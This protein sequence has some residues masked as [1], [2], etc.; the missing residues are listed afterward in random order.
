M[1]LRGI[2]SITPLLVIGA[3]ST[4]ADAQC[5][6]GSYSYG[7]GQ[8]ASCPAG[9][10]FVSA[11]SGCAPSASLTS[12]PPDTAFYLSG[13]GS[14]EVLAFPAV[15]APTSVSAAAG[16]F[17]AQS[18]G[19]LELSGGSHLSAPGTSAPEALPGGGNVPWSASAWVK[20]AAPETH[21]TGTA[22]KIASVLEWG[23]P[24]DVLGAASTQAISLDVKV[25]ET[26]TKV[27]DV[28]VSTL[29]I[30]PSSISMSAIAVMADGSVIVADTTGG[31]LLV[32]YLSP[33]SSDLATLAGGAT[34]ADGS[35]ARISMAWDPGLHVVTC[36]ENW[37]CGP[38]TYYYSYDAP[39][40]GVGS[41]ASFGDLMFSNQQIVVGMTQASSLD[42]VIVTES[43]CIRTISYPTGTVTTLAG[44]C[45]LQCCGFTNSMWSPR[46]GSALINFGAAD[47]TGTSAKFLRPRFPSFVESIS[48]IFVLDG[49]MIRSISYPGAV[50][51]S[52]KMMETREGSFAAC[53][54][55]SGFLGLAAAY[56]IAGLPMGN[57]IVLASGD[58]PQD[59][60]NYD[61]LTNSYT[62]RSWLSVLSFSDGLHTPL[63]GSCGSLSVGSSGSMGFTGLVSGINANT[64]YG[65]TLT[66]REGAT[67][68]PSIANVKVL[69]VLPHGD[70][71]VVDDNVPNAPGS[72]LR[73]VSRTG[74][75]S[76]LAGG[77]G[78]SFGH[79]DGLGAVSSFA[80][81][82]ALAVHARTG[83]IVVLDT[84]QGGTRIRKAMP[85]FSF[86]VCDS[87]WHHI[88]LTYSPTA[89][90]YTLTAFLDGTRVYST[91]IRITLPAASDPSTSLRVG[92]SGDSIKNAGSPFSGSLSELR[93]YN[94]TLSQAEVVAL[95]QPPLGAFA[96]L[97]LSTRAAPQA[98]ARAYA[99]ACNAGSAGPL[100]SMLLRSPVDKSWAWAGAGGVAPVCTPCAAGFASV[101]GASSNVCAPCPPGMY[102]LGGASSCTLCPP[103]TYGGSLALG[104]SACSGPC[105]NCPAGSLTL[106][107]A[108]L[109]CTTGGVRAVPNSFG[110]QLWPAGNPDNPR[111]VDLVIAPLAQCQQMMSAG[112]CTS[113]ATYVGVDGVTRYVVGAAADLHL[114]AGAPLTCSG[115]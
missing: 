25:G 92:W 54:F 104:T 42:L 43:F 91:A 66:S 76:T 88:A 53:S 2:P 100:Q 34:L 59:I 72:T 67:A 10:T 115:Y 111:N 55:S 56:S 65:I 51:N 64:R 81:I 52:I 8:C 74:K 107:D 86:P 26:E 18:G 94:R 14:T 85:V 98:G 90:P 31:R 46:L 23:A 75:V 3:F 70:I 7:S 27:G 32:R 35:V 95:S 48:T 17:G 108:S 84:N 45:A 49:D 105:L 71:L 40:D 5:P 58:Q 24:G 20:C 101:A 63:T 93:I 61:I 12:G 29:A 37:R 83:M 44:L 106:P 41:S 68:E 13:G 33:S 79:S 57:G 109:S 82:T 11:S 4:A 69:A 103:G 15:A 89:A 62:P 36:D 1:I 47:G 110:L 9:A 87:T 6:P 28:L 78:S 113:A 60:S 102:S 50:V 96:S 97:H 39:V 99:F 112:A 21:Y 30:I 19:A 80:H 77:P 73:T 22:P 38:Q 16:P 114:E